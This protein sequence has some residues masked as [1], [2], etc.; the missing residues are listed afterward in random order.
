MKKM[1]IGLFVLTILFTLTSCSFF[2]KENENESNNSDDATNNVEYDKYVSS[3]LEEGVD[4]ISHTTTYDGRNFQYDKS[5]WYIN[6]LDKVPLPD[7]QIFVEDGI[8]YIVGTNDASTKVVTCYTTT[9]FNTYQYA[10][11][12]YNPARYK[13]W[14]KAD[15]AIYA[16]EM[17]CFEGVYYLYYSALD[18]NNI[19]RNSVVSATSPLGPYEPIVNDEVD[20]LS[21]PLFLDQNV[22]NA[23]LDSTIFVDDDNT[24]YMYY[25]VADV[26]GQH[27]V[28]V[29]LNSPYDADWSTY[30]EIVK[31][32][33]I[34]SS[35]TLKP[36]VWEEYRNKTAI[37]EAPYMIKSNGKYYM[38][39]SVN[40]CWNKYYNV[41]YA[42]SDSPLGNYV[43]PYENGK[44]WTNL[45]LGY[46][47]DKLDF[48][49]VYQQWSGFASGTGH[50]SFFMIGDQVMIAYHAH[51]NRDWNSES[52]Y[53]KRYLAIDYLYFDEEGVPYCNGPTWS[54]QPLPEGISGYK[55]IAENSIIKCKNV[56]NV[57]YVNDNYIE[58]CY[59]LVQDNKEVNLG[60]G[61]SFIELVFD[62][63][64]EIGGIAIY[65]SAF[66]DKMIEE[67]VYIDFGN[68]NVVHYPQFCLET[69]TNEDLEFVHPCSAITVEFATTVKAEKVIICFNLPE[70][71]S[72]NEIK[73]LGK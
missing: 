71:G 3:N 8:Y 39:Y 68:G 36:L 15:P 18:K 58:D 28:G 54:L 42:V 60:N 40:G 35:F 48:N 10:G 59:N 38:T 45:L 67:V 41:C 17:Y 47:G 30:T 6:N 37:A 13:G 52:A 14:E 7:P 1:L 5:A 33:Y 43:K 4:Y 32:G 62:Q 29:K 19:R 44:L 2:S 66:F 55:N 16:P 73:V 63:E 46:P 27:I 57:N 9:D 11:E 25:S 49:K 69:Y 53:T 50:H 21:N 56:E 34:D 64:Y 22:K 72:I 23:V 51:Q 26:Y 31:P 65:N 20:G 70:G 24:M 12:I 61:Y